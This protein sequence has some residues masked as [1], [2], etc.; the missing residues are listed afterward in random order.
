MGKEILAD[1]GVMRRE[2]E[3][4]GG[5]RG[6]S[7]VL[8]SFGIGNSRAQR[9]GNSYVGGRSVNQERGII[10]GDIYGSYEEELI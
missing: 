10:L 4:G 9:R 7:I 5:G 8:L 6:S 1:K 2:S 3:A